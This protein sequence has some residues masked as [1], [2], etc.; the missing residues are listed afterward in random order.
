MDDRTK[1]FSEEDPAML[2]ERLNLIL[3]RHGA[4]TPP[5][6]TP[7]PDVGTDRKSLLKANTY[8]YPSNQDD[9]PIHD[10]LYEDAWKAINAPKPTASQQSKKKEY[11]YPSN[12]DDTPIYNNLTKT[13]R[14]HLP[15]EKTKDTPAPA[16]K[17]KEDTYKRI[18]RERREYEEKYGVTFS[19][20]KVI[21]F[22]LFVICLMALITHFKLL[23]L[24]VIAFFWFIVCQM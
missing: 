24:I 5:V 7:T 3:K 22:I 23:P 9:T 15:P 14:T 8:R 2:E 6:S 16:P 19:I 17:S 4:R 1:S 20:L 10:D 11:R 21:A 12:Q 18:T 13:P